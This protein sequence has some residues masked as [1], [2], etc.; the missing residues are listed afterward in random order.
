MTEWWKSLL[1]NT[2]YKKKMKRNGNRLRDL[3]NHIKHTSICIL[4]IPEGEKRER[5]EKLFGEI[6]AENFPNMGKEILN[7]VPELQSPRQD[8]QKEEHTRTH[9][10][11]T[12][13]N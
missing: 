1:Q 11:Q 6:I 5:T 2:T 12:D 7:Q 8:K 10:N 3:W 4:G 9:S 13:K